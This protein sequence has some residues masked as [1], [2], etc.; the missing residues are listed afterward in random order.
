MSAKFARISVLSV[1][2]NIPSSL[3]RSSNANIIGFGLK[4][5][6]FKN[7]LVYQEKTNVKKTCIGSRHVTTNIKLVI[8]E[9]V[10]YFQSILYRQYI[11]KAVKERQKWYYISLKNYLYIYSINLPILSVNLLAHIDCH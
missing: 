7:T 11:S 5:S 10:Q 1:L 8:T 4:A 9:Y 2:Q 3:I 6:E